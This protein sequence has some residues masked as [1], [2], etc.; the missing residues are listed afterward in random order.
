MHLG[1]DEVGHHTQETVADITALLPLT[2]TDRS[3]HHT[4]S[5]RHH[6]MV[7]TNLLNHHIR[8]NNSGMPSTLSLMPLSHI[9]TARLCPRTTIRITLRSCISNSSNNNIPKGSSRHMVSSH[10]HHPLSRNTASL[11]KLRHLS[12]RLPL[13]SGVLTLRSNKAMD[14]FQALAV[15]AEAITTEVEQSRR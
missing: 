15:D 2:P 9:R 12:I 14:S 6:L 3:S 5:S 1:E 13:S 4:H 11:T 8:L 10:M 7:L